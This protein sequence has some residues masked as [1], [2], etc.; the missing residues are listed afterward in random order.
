MEAIR[1]SP[2][3]GYESGQRVEAEIFIRNQKYQ[4]YFQS[5]QVIL[6]SSPEALIAAVLLPA[7]KMR[8][9]QINIDAPVSEQFLRGQQEIQKVFQKWKPNYGSVTV[10]HSGSHQR[11]IK[12]GNTGIFFSAG[13][14]SYYSFLTHQDE[15]DALIYLDGFD[16]PLGEHESR[17]RMH[18]NLN[19]IGEKFGKQVVCIET[20]LREFQEKFLTWTFGH[21]S[22]IACVGHLISGEFTRFFVSSGG[23]PRAKKPFGVH[24][25]LDPNWS[26]EWV[27]FIH[28]AYTVDRIEKCRFISQYEPVWDS[29]RVCLRYPENSLN[30]GVCEKCLRTQVYFQVT[31]HYDRYT[32]FER[33]LDLNALS[34]YK[35]IGSPEKD[36]LFPALEMLEEQNTYPETAVVLR[37][38]LFP[39]NWMQ[40]WIQFVRKLNKKIFRIHYKK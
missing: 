36:L 2:I 18:E 17:A 10:Q 21:G 31:G 39:G 27:E 23:N 8:A 25:E 15:I 38:I 7:M 35:R 4:V 1:I 20:N 24:P 12:G 3:S 40:K 28:D 5:D 37:K 33:P 32:V 6:H 26:S 9:D 19:W 34:K 11:E 29:L 14:D 16:I 22:A 13:V 30:C